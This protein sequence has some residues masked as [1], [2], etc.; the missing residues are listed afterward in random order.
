LGAGKSEEKNLSVTLRYV[1]LRLF[2][3]SA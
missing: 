2:L 3:S 1:M